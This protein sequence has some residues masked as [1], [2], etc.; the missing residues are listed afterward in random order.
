MIPRQFHWVWVGPARLPAKDEAWMQSWRTRHPG[1]QCIIWAEHPENVSLEG[2]E[3]RSLPP[4]ANQR[5][6]DGIE[7]WV[8]GRAVLASR[9]DIVRYE[10]IARSGGIYL[11]TDV[12]CF[13]NINE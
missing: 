8:T 12:E 2:F 9:S 7:Q 11:D 3:T 5:F 6:Y 4:L 13:G 1:W 10:V